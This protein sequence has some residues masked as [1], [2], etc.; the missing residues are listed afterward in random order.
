MD[1]AVLGS[2]WA[3]DCRVMC[4][5]EYRNTRK[6]ASDTFFSLHMQNTGRTLNLLFVFFPTHCLKASHQGLVGWEWL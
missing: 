5:M 1:C 2:M 3:A 6:N 4:T